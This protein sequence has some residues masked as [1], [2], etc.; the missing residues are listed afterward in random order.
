MGDQKNC[1][2]RRMAG[3]EL[4]RAVAFGRVGRA[5]ALAVDDPTALRGSS[6]PNSV[7]TPVRARRHEMISP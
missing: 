3:G 6:A 2:F 1:A 5:V 4:K 7:L